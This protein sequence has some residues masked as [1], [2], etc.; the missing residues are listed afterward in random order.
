MP[1]DLSRDI[2]L[3]WESPDLSHIALFKQAGITAVLPSTVEASFSEACSAAGIA[4]VAPSEIQLLRQ[5]ELGAAK[6]GANVALTGGLWPGISR[7]AAVSGRGDETASASVEP[8]VDSNGYWI[9]YLRAIYPKRPSVL[10]YLPDKLGDRAVPF[11]SLELA[12]IEAWTA[13]G[14]YILAVE[15]RYREAL[16]RREPKAIS[17]W[18]QLGRTARWLRENIALFRQ[19]ALPIVTALVEPGAATAEIGNLLYRRHVSP[20]LW[21]AAAPPPTDPRQ[22]LALVAANLRRPEP[23]LVK[24]IMAHAEAGSSVIA[25][26][27]PAE[28][29]WQSAALKPVRSE[30][31]REFFAVGKGQLVAYR[32]PIADPS[33]FA[34]DVI[35]I[36]THKNRAVR[37]WNTLAVIALVTNSPRQGERVLH[38]INYGSPID[39]DVQVRV[40]GHFTKAT[41]L[42]PDAPPAPLQAAKRGATTE[43]FLPEIKRL[44]VVVFS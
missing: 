33:E 10:G 39:A 2:V 4:T 40:Q 31:D 12:L 7:P 27:P 16:L 38:V 43:V 24:Q 44:A 14:N 20:L 28:Q 23:G 35:D 9:G 32:R 15:P 6:P 21:P 8:W 30:P 3:R 22:R 19:P 17:A 13:G 25:A 36:I 18:E 34:L 5:S 42:R 11:D 1:L 29:W 41:L 37:L 26:A